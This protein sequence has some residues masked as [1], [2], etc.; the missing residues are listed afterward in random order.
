MTTTSLEEQLAQALQELQVARQRMIDLR[1]Q[2]PQEAV[3]D[4]S[5]AGPEG[6]QF[7]LS[8]LFGDK[9]DLIVIHNMG[10]SCVYC[11]MWADGFN[12]ILPHLQDR[13]A[14]VVIS[15]DAP[16][17][18]Q[19][20]ASQRGWRFPMVSSAG[21]S[22]RADLGFQQGDDLMPGVSVLRKQDD[23]SIVHVARDMFGPGDDYCATWHLFDLLPAGSAGWEPRFSYT[24]Q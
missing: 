7:P 14:F 16:E 12:G 1:R 15:P 24:A 23:G 19:E 22:F 21:T 5:F 18:Q 3:R 6:V 13:A 2:L 8:R 20:F 11:T 10:T 17:I 9:P 4:Y